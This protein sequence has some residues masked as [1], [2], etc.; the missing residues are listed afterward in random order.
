MVARKKNSPATGANKKRK[1]LKKMGKSMLRNLKIEKWHDEDDRCFPQ[2]YRWTWEIETEDHVKNYKTS[3]RGEG[4]WIWVSNDGWKQIAGTCD[5]VL[6]DMSVS[7]ARKKI[8]RYLEL[9]E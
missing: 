9:D 2:K 4:I 5:F 3:D 8:K 6:W 1:G 7:G